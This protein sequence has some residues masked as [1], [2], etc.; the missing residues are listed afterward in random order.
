MYFQK[1]WINVYR[2]SIDVELALQFDHDSLRSKHHELNINYTEKARAHARTQ[3]MYDALK[4][5][6]LQHEVHFAAADAAE[7]T[8]NAASGG[9]STSIQPRGK[10]DMY[11]Q[12]V[13]T[14]RHGS[15]YREQDGASS[16]RGE[17]FERMDWQQR[18]T[19][20]GQPIVNQS[21]N[22]LTVHALSELMPRRFLWRF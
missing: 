17:G 8:L 16:G 2:T 13:P 22:V 6:M 3:K 12:Q 9:S 7:V 20:S 10:N 1:D 14:E 15:R 4:K 5:Q 21:R 19:V 18:G 11:R